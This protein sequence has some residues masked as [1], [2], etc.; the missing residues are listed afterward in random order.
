[1]FFVFEKNYLS[2]GD[3][4][5]VEVPD[6]EL[7]HHKQNAIDEMNRRKQHYIESENNNFTFMPDESDEDCYVFADGLCEQCDDR[8]GE[9]HICMIE[10]TPKDHLLAT[11]ILT[12]EDIDLYNKLGNLV[13]SEISERIYDRCNEPENFSRIEDKVW[14][15]LTDPNDQFYFLEFFRHLGKEIETDD[16]HE[17]WSGCL[18]NCDLIYM[19]AIAYVLNLPKPKSSCDTYIFN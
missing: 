5:C 1:M 6:M 11:D 8:D 19:Q 13:D 16:E 12:R 10:L 4:D 14:S 17:F 3:C 9:F 15:L 2:G 18:Y 7:F